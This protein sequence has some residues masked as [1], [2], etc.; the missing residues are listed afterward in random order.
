MTVAELIAKLQKMPQDARVQMG[1]DGN[2]VSIQPGGN[3]FV[4][5]AVSDYL[6]ALPGDVF[7]EGVDLRPWKLGPR[8]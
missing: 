7:I 5:D 3:V 1:F 4:V 2:Y 6:Y 8:V